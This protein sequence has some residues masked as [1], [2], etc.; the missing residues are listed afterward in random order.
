LNSFDAASL[1][2]LL[3]QEFNSREVGIAQLNIIRDSSALLAELSH[4]DA[5]FDH[6][7]KIREILF[8][9]NKTVLLRSDSSPSSWELA[10]RAQFNRSPDC[11]M[12]GIKTRASRGGRTWAPGPTTRAHAKAV[13]AESTATAQSECNLKLQFHGSTAFELIGVIRNLVSAL[14]LQSPLREVEDDRLDEGEWKLARA[15]PFNDFAGGAVFRLRDLPEMNSVKSK[16]AGAVVYVG[17][18]PLGVEVTDSVSLAVEANN[19]A[20][21]G[22]ARAGPSTRR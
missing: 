5:A 4:Q 14:P 19:S 20:R 11:I 2:N 18:A 7:S 16:L 10:M 17:G 12:M 22:A 15:G 1:V 21:R 13:A 8:I 3:R 9:N 6:A